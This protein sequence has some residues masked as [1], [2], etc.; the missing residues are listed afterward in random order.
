[1]SINLKK[2]L[3]KE[4][5]LEE[6]TLTIDE[7]NG[8]DNSGVS[9]PSSMSSLSPTLSGLTSGNIK[10]TPQHPWIDMMI[11]VLGVDLRSLAAMRMGLSLLI[12][13]DLY[14]RALYLHDHYTD[15][16][17]VP[18]SQVVDSNPYNCAFSLFIGYK[19]FYSNLIC[20]VF[21]TSL[22]VRN[23]LVL[24]GEQ[25]NKRVNILNP[26]SVTYT[27][28]ISTNPMF[29]TTDSEGKY[30]MSFATIAIMFQFCIVYYATAYLKHGDEWNKEYSSVWFALNLDQFTTATGIW[31]RQFIRA[32]MFLTWITI[33]FEWL[34]YFLFFIPFKKI[35]GPAR[36]LGV[37]GFWCMHIGFGSCLELGFFMYIP[38]MCVLVFT[39]SWFWDNIL[40]WIYT[41]SRTSIV[42]YYNTKY[43]SVFKLL[44][45]YKQFFLVNSTPILPALRQDEDTFTDQDSTIYNDMKKNNAWIAI[46]DSNTLERAYGYNAFI[47]LIKMS[48]ILR[49]TGFIFR[50]KLVRIIY[51][52]ITN[53]STNAS[54]KG[55]KCIDKLYPSTPVVVKRSYF[56]EIA[57]F[58]LL[59][60]VLNWNLAGLYQ[61]SVPTSIR[62]IAP[63][64]KIDQF[65]A[66][67]S[68]YPSKDNG[69][70][71]YPG[72]L[73]DG[74]EIDI[75]TGRNVTYEKPELISATF[76]TQRW[77]KYLMN[78][79]SSYH[80]DKRLNYGKYLCR[81]WNWWGRHPGPKQLVSYKIVFMW[82]VT[83]NMPQPG[84]PLPADPDYKQ[85][86][87]W[88]HKC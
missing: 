2:K 36:F 87:L 27:P 80:Q 61:Y 83:P 41:P 5:L 85:I 38:G 64:L 19:T 77:R 78:L 11:K 10:P 40:D 74:S 81:E 31:A 13:L 3:S 82:G 48:P 53:L 86:I 65:W 75:F 4:N 25:T 56:K 68:P 63:V 15:Y 16:A 66:M 76:P 21:M 72:I 29:P 55:W 54:T 24:N 88:D 57:C 17:A 42:I 39:P 58:L 70:L 51:T 30:Y 46:E 35:H 8:T 43:D 23:P 79:Q 20:W 22:H 44:A 1:M 32:G 37:V 59:I 9:S 47:Q 49:F 60:Y 14:V 71:V 6:Y 33:K 73:S 12:M 50:L 26:K 67:F 7:I 45:M 18:T 28:I 84:E 69:W 62:W 34:G 52:K